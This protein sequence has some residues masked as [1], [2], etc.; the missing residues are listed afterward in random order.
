M[1]FETNEAL[2]E[3]VQTDWLRYLVD[4][5]INRKVAIKQSEPSFYYAG[6][7]LSVDKFVYYLA[8]MEKHKVMWSEAVLNAAINFVFDELGIRRIF[9]HSFET[10]VI[11]KGIKC[12]KPPKSLYTD[13]PKKF[14]FE[15]VDAGPEFIRKDKKAKRHLKAIKNPQRFTMGN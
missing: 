9:F 1:D 8:E 3:E 11:L 6:I 13:L 5:S 10:G 14:C 4:C 15:G 2:I 7:E 12:T